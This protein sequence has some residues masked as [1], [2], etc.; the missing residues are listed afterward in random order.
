VSAELG[1]FV[2]LGESPLPRFTSAA[3]RFAGLMPKYR[4]DASEMAKARALLN[5]AGMTVVNRGFD[6]A[7]N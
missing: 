6:A 3:G 7:I 5:A 4:P 1:R 2:E